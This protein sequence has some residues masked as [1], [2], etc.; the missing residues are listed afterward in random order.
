MALASISEAWTQYD[1]SLK[2]WQ[3]Q[4]TSENL[5]EAI[6]YLMGHEPQ[7]MS[8]AGRSYNREAMGQLRD[9]LMLH[10]ESGQSGRPAFTAR[11]RIRGQSRFS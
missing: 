6:L 3:S 11:A 8:F 4:T 1:A 5:L 10:V 7:A 2:Y 9:K